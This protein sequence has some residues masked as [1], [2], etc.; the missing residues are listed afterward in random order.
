MIRSGL[1]A[2]VLAAT[3]LVHPP[4]GAAQTRLGI[5]AGLAFPSGDFGRSTNTGVNIEGNFEVQP[6]GMPFALRG[7]LFL[8]RFG[9]DEDE[10]G[11]NGSIRAFGAALSAL[12][13]LAGAG[14]TPYVLLGPTLTNLDISLDGTG[15]EAEIGTNVGVQGGAG[16][17][18][19]L[20]GY[21]TRFEVRVGQVFSEDD[22]IGIPDARWITVNLG[23]LFGGRGG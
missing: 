12:F 18:F 22:D 23:V 8:S 2:L 21:L 15:D 1:V 11:E 16:L 5:A 20:S 4:S 14:I 7:D 10:T 19:L 17:K 3:V 13:Q 9:I 6:G